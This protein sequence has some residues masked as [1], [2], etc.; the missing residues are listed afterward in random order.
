MTPVYGPVRHRHDA[1]GQHYPLPLHAVR[2]LVAIVQDA[3]VPTRLVGVLIAPI[4]EADA[5]IERHGTPAGVAGATAPFV[6]G[7][8]KLGKQRR[9]RLE[10]ARVAQVRESVID[11][12]DCGVED[13]AVGRRGTGRLI[14]AGR[15]RGTG[16]L[17][18]HRNSAAVWRWAWW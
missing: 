14:G 3:L 6:D 11:V 7:F 12:P 2:A 15:L 1:V 16:R 17:R 4:D 10:R 8:G 18:G 5:I 13:S 9:P